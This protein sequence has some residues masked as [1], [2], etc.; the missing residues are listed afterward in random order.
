[1]SLLF[2]LCILVNLASTISRNNIKTIAITII[3]YYQNKYNFCS[4]NITS[5]NQE[6][7]SINTYPIH[8]KK[9]KKTPLR[10]ARSALIHKNKEG[11]QVKQQTVHLTMCLQV[12]SEK[13][14]F[15]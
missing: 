6:T 1:L 3:N 11:N 10:T 12:W 14:M 8:R 9:K 5:K 15:V 2:S 4:W 13:E 7:R